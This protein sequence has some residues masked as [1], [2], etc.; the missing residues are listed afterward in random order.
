MWKTRRKVRILSGGKIGL[1]KA[2]AE[3]YESHHYL[4]LFKCTHIHTCRPT[5][6]SAKVSD[7]SPKYRNTMTHSDKGQGLRNTVFVN[8][9]ADTERQTRTRI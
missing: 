1:C 4:L 5:D 8:R 2:A 7:I 6:T 3:T 9:N